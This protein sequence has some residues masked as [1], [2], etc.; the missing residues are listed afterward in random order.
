M[1]LIN[2]FLNLSISIS[3]IFLHFFQCCILK[4]PISSVLNILERQIFQFYDFYFVFTISNILFIFYFLNPCNNFFYNLIIN[5]YN[6]I[7]R[8]YFNDKININMSMFFLK[9]KYVDVNMN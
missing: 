1:F 6:I 9:N 7:I 4:K 3:S 2:E 5:Y 8:L